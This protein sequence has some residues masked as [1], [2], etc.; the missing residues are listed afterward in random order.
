MQPNTS[1]L[2]RK[3]FGQPRWDDTQVN[4]WTKGDGRALSFSNS[5]ADIKAGFR[6]GRTH[7]DLTGA[8]GFI[9]DNLYNLATAMVFGSTTSASSWEAFQQAIK[10]LTKVFAN[11]LDLVVKKKKYL[12]MLKREETDPC[13]TITRTYP[14]AINW[15]IINENGTRLDIPARIYVDNALMLAIDRA[16]MEMALA[17]A[18]EAIFAVVGI[19]PDGYQWTNPLP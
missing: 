14:C 3:A 19:L 13:I 6:F 1:R 11:K 4:Y 7:A 9:A 5:M 16:H 17:A 15:G 12:D 2:P 8:F 10:A 18:V